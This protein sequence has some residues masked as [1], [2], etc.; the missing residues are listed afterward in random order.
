[1]CIVRLLYDVYDTST[2][3]LL[4][5]YFYFLTSVDGSTITVVGKQLIVLWPLNLLE[6]R[7]QLH[8]LSE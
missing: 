6:D 3:I 4:S 5:I 1:M 8:F 2:L 7:F